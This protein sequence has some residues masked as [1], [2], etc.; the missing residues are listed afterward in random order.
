[1]GDS[2]A[3]GHICKMNATQK[4]VS[5]VPRMVNYGLAKVVAALWD[6]YWTLWDHHNEHLH[7]TD[8]ANKLLDMATVDNAIRCKW[9]HGIEGLNILDQL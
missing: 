8:I 4:I 5:I 3:I 2:A 9:K 7:N 6:Y 1:M